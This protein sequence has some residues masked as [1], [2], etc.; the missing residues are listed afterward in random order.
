MGIIIFTM[1]IKGKTIEEVWGRILNTIWY[2]GM[3]VKSQRGKTKEILN[4]SAQ[5]TAPYDKSIKGFPMG[6]AELDIYSKQLVKK[7]KGGFEYTY[8]ERLRAWGPDKVDQ[9]SEII[10]ILKRSKGT[11]RAT[12]VTWI[13][14]VDLKKNEIPC[15]IM[16][17]FKVR[18]GR[19]NL[20]AIFR[21]N[22]MFGAWPANMYGLNKLN[23]LVAKKINAKA[24]TITT[25]SISAHVYD[26][27]FEN[28]KKVLGV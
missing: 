5:V 9:I 14:P 4:L 10:K 22:D 6:Q 23:L 16:A 26:Y 15:L 24:A 18:L 8:G 28:M 2:N 12:A 13:P 7:D 25:H 27:D 20:T 17:D 11:R 21:S 19:L 1:F 3:T